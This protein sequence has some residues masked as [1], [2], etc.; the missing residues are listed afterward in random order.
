[1]MGLGFMA[2]SIRSAS[3]DAT[4]KPLIP[5]ELIHQLTRCGGLG[6]IGTAAASTRAI[7]VKPGGI[8]HDQRLALEPAKELTR[9]VDIQRPARVLD[10]RTALRAVAKLHVI[11]VPQYEDL[12]S[13]W[14][15]GRRVESRR[16]VDAHATIDIQLQ[17]GPF[18]NDELSAFREL[19]EPM[20]E[21]LPMPTPENR[22]FCEIVS[23]VPH[24]P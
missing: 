6:F 18:G 11:V 24:F 20:T 22:L 5:S 12:Q 2:K 9:S 16:S 17:A 14:R 10:I 21:L 3:P 8:T 7:H 23:F 19:E 1:V 13:A 4:S 15:I